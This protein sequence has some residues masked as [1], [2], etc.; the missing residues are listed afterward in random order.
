MTAIENEDPKEYQSFLDLSKEMLANYKESVKNYEAADFQPGEAEL[1]KPVREANANYLKMTEDMIAHMEQRTPEGREHVYKQLKNGEYRKVAG[2]IRKSLEAIMKMYTDLTVTKNKEQLAEQ[3]KI[4][5]Q[6]IG[7]AIASFVVIFAAMLIFGQKISS[8]ISHIAENLKGSGGE[9]STAVDQLS[10]AGQSLAQSST[11]AAASLEETVASL[12]EMTSMVKINSENSKQAAALALVSKDR[13]EVGEKEIK[14]LISSM[15]DIS[16]S[17]K[18]IE[19]IISVIDDIAFQTNLLALN[20]SVEAARAGEQGKGFAVVADAVRSLALKSAEAAK[21]I[22]GLIKES[23][24]KISH[25]TGI[26]DKSGAVLSEIVVSIKKVSDLNNEIS[27]ANSEQ[28]TGIQQV[29]KAM[30]QLDQSSQQNAAASEQIAGT[31]EQISGEAGKVH[32]LV[33][34]LGTLVSGKAA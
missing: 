2:G 12:E 13:A 31:A 9:V 1:Y 7:T 27:A 11:E 25:G 20:A 10:Q 28:T 3:D 23:V 6:V 22:S 16:S 8:S 4:E 29:S 26:A 19:E 21:D 33:K 5:V 24:E 30:Q 32:S 34:E 18:K 14:S 15:H 17:S